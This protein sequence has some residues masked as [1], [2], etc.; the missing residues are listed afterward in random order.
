VQQPFPAELA[1]SPKAIEAL[2]YEEAH[3][4]RIVCN[5]EPLLPRRGR[6]FAAPGLGRRHD[7]PREPAEAVEDAANQRFRQKQPIA[8]GAVRLFQQNESREGQDDYGK[9]ADQPERQGYA[10]D[11]AAMPNHANARRR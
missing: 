3:L 2:R 1:S 10:E 4:T 6:K 11:K 8:D 5:G 9:A 7:H